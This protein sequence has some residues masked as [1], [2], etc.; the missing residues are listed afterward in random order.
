MQ[1]YNATL[2]VSRPTP[3]FSFVADDLGQAA[4]YNSERQYKHF[5]LK[6]IDFDLSMW[7]AVNTETCLRRGNQCYSLGDRQLILLKGWCQP[8]GGLSVYSTPSIDIAQY[9]QKP[10]VVVSSAMDSRSLFHD[11]TLGV[12][13]DLSGM[14]SVLAIA[15]AL[16]KVIRR[17]N[18][19]LAT[20][21]TYHAR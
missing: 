16:S 14:V 13:Y 20:W 8:V 12:H 10:I 4:A 17:C 6:A 11:L 9:D 21:C 2:Q 19:V 3:Q 5:P 18:E 1:A 15:D 7:A